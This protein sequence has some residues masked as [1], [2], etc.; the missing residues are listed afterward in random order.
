[1]TE[2]SDEKAVI[3]LMLLI[4]VGGLTLKFNHFGNLVVDNNKEKIF[5]HF[6]IQ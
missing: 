4:D 5:T 1:M 2:E 6:K 3:F